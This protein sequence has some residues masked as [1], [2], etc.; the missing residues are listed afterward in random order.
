MAFNDRNTLYILVGLPGSGKS[1]WTQKYCKSDPSCMVLSTDNFIEKEAK[2]LGKT[3]DDVMKTSYKKAL[4][5][6][7]E[8]LSEAVRLSKNIVWDQTN[9]SVDSRKSKVKMPAL[10]DYY[11]VAVYFPTPPPHEWKRRLKSRPGKTIPMKVLKGMEEGLSPPTKDEG[12]DEV[13]EIRD[14]CPAPDVTM[15]CA[16][17]G[18]FILK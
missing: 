2:R 6:L 1:T 5:N 14:V 17:C 10:R 8:M 12:F 16:I 3:Y 11:K 9:L 4:K 13:R 18:C 7:Q 15:G